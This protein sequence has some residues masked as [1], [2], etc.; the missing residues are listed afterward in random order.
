MPDF[1][2]LD[3]YFR[4]TDDS[5]PIDGWYINTVRDCMVCGSR[6]IGPKKG[7]DYDYFCSPECYKLK[8][9]K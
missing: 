9:N 8:N 7:T 2:P 5:K 3:H 1:D 4:R 6:F